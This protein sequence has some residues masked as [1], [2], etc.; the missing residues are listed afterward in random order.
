MPRQPRLDAPGLIQHV[1]ARGIERREI[2]QDDKDRKSFLDRLAVIF[3]ETQTQ[4]YAWA[5]TPTN[6]PEVLIIEPDVFAIS[7]PMARPNWYRLSRGKSLMWLSILE[8]DRQPSVSGLAYA[9][10]RAISDNYLRQ[11]ALRMGIVY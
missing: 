9:F 7:I 11:G 3:E 4:C 1:M 2:F 5:L 8:Q 10:Q 6:I